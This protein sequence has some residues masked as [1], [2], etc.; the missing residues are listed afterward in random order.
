MTK[1]DERQP[2]EEHLRHMQLL[3]CKLE[4]SV[5]ELK[6]DLVFGYAVSCCL[7][8]IYIRFLKKIFCG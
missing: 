7:A 6:E 2:R 4:L 8:L 5:L 3:G 1:L